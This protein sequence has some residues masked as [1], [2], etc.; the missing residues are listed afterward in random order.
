MGIEIH[1]GR[2]NAPAELMPPGGRPRKTASPGRPAN[3]LDR[4]LARKLLQLI[5]DSGVQI[6]LWDGSEVD[7][8]VREPVAN[9]H[10]RDRAALYETLRNP[11]LN[12]GDCF[13]LGRVRVEGDLIGLLQAAYKGVSRG[14]AASSLLKLVRWYNHRRSGQAQG[15]GAQDIHHH[16]DI[17]N[18]FYRRW[19]DRD[20]MQYTCAYYPEP[21]M[22]VEEA[23]RAK[24]DHVCRKLQ[25]EPGQQVVEAGCG[26]GGFALHMAEHFGVR[27]KAFNISREQVRYAKQKARE[28]GL[29]DRVEYVLD[30]FRNIEGRFDAF[31]SIGML[32]HVGPKNYPLLG[33]VVARVLKPDG[34][35]LIH[36]IGRNRPKPM[37][38]WIEKRIFP[39]AYP[40]ALGEMMDIFEPNPLSVLDV[41]NLRLHYAQTLEDWLERFEQSADLVRQETD[42][43]FVRTWRL[44]LS[45]SVAAFRTGDLQLFQVL[46]T[47]QENHHLPRSRQYQFPGVR[48]Q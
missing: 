45:G 7:P 9:M 11:E 23:Q 26:W 33:S 2:D 13:A 30:D 39:G 47:H 44:Y 10:F 22:S 35:G 34:F 36:S 24:M 20:A 38:A 4:W 40:P 3:R 43:R 6:S 41:E 18:E 28:R 14:K 31:V 15:S 17:G 16:Y 42:E 27:V 29:D 19:L 12:W 25:L 37:N 48:P 46:F 32:E 8:A 21:E 1:R 5:G